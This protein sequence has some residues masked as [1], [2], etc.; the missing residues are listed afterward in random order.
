MPS[1]TAGQL[2]DLRRAVRFAMAA[3]EG[4]KP[5]PI[6]LSH[7][8]ARSFAYHVTR[9]RLSICLAPHLDSLGLPDAAATIIAADARAERFRALAQAS[10]TVEAEKVLTDAGIRVLVIKGVA[11]AVQT[12]GDLTGR[13]RGDIDLWVHPR[14]TTRAA[15]VL[16]GIGFVGYPGL[17]VSALGSPAWRYHLWVDYE[18]PLGRD[19]TPLDLHWWL[20]QPRSALPG[21]DHAWARREFVTISSRSVPT[22]SH[23]D[24]LHHSCAHAL[25]D[26]WRSLRSLIDIDRLAR[27]ASAGERERLTRLRAVRLGTAAAFDSTG[28]PY[29]RQW[30]STDPRELRRMRHIADSQR[31]AERWTEQEQ[32]RASATWQWWRQQVVLARTGGDVAR[33]VAGL[34]L[35]P[36]TFAARENAADL[37]IGQGVTERARLALSRV[38]QR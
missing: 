38:R 32:W 15:E 26:G 11:L 27:S 17:T 34:V 10:V 1:F 29:L 28:S 37:T 8:D 30:A 4:R 22:L 13:G 9:H 19:G 7:V 21:F 16:A 36:A 2:L 18:A 20:T 33:A 35:P 24:A 31:R 25:K 6:S 3:E 14:D 23:G 12:T 5:R